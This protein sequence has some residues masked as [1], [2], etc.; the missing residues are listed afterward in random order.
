MGLQMHA[1]SKHKELLDVK[2][3]ELTGESYVDVEDDKTV[4]N[5]KSAFFREGFTDEEI[6]FLENYFTY[7]GDDRPVPVYNEEPGEHG[8]FDEEVESFACSK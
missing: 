4:K 8:K 2:A 1:F 7:L 5:A 6:G 3:E